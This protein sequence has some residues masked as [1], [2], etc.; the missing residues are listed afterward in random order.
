M[1]G[2]APRSHSTPSGKPG[3]HHS[4]WTTYKKHKS[5]PIQ[6]DLT[7]EDRIRKFINSFPKQ[8]LNHELAKFCPVPDNERLEDKFE[9]FY[10]PYN[11]PSN[12]RKY[13]SYDEY[14]TGRL[15]SCPFKRYQEWLLENHFLDEYKQSMG[16][17]RSRSEPQREMQQSILL[18]QMELKNEETKQFEGS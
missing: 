5:K 14:G 1:S 15:D 13:I 10:R 8:S 2:R 17:G 16:L 12:T 6:L 4:H 3:T 9:F 7:L 18:F 11:Y